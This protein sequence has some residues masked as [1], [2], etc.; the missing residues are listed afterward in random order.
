MYIKKAGWNYL[1]NLTPHQHADKNC[2]EKERENKKKNVP[3]NP[4]LVFFF[5]IETSIGITLQ[6]CGFV[7]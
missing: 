3:L 1:R 6:D 2:K 4:N 7:S 5:R